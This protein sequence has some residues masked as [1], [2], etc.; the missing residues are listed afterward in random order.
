[1]GQA[2][3]VFFSDQ[4]LATGGFYAFYDIVIEI[5]AVHAE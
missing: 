2:L 5:T 1:V 3:G 4:I